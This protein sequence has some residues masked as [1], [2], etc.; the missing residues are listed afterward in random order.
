MYVIMVVKSILI[1][2]V[3]YYLIIILI[4]HDFKYLGSF[5]IN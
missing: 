2:Y 3:I 1:T 5:Y 4:T